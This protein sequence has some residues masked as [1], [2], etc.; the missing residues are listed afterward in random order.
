[1]SAV[2]GACLLIRRDLFFKVGRLDENLAVAGGDVELCLRVMDAGYRNLVLPDVRLLH[3]ESITR[4]Y[5]DTAKK[6][7]RFLTETEY[8]RKRWPDRMLRDP[9]YNPNLTLEKEDFSIR[10][11]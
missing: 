5:E 4:G 9:F 11:N 2:T 7:E 3:Y 1:V 6:H 10:F 8:V